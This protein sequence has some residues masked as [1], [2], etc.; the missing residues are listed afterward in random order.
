MYSNTISTKYTT[1]FY[2]VPFIRAFDDEQL[3]IL[4]ET[5]WRK[6]IDTVIYLKTQ[7]INQI[8]G[9]IMFFALPVSLVIEKTIQ[10]RED[11]YLLWSVKVANT[12]GFPNPQ[13]IPVQGD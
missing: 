9:S 7:L 12:N 11:L 5:L 6:H 8:V 1:P 10:N 2:T 3:T 4:K 13:K